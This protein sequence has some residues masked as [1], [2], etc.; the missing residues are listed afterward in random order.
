[1]MKSLTQ[2]EEQVMQVLWKLG[3]GFLKD[4][5]K[6]SPEPRPHANTVATIL[7]ILVE[8]GFVSFSTHGRNNLYRPLVSK[9]E[10]GRRLINRLL[11]GYFDGSPSKLMSQLVQDKKLSPEELDALLEQIRNAK[12]GNL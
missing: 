11:K 9:D 10:Y 8:K 3:Q 2:S 4:M 12:N 1:M 7:K 6:A 5:L